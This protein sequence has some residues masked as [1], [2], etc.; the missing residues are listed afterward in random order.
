[1]PATGNA[2]G[3]TRWRASQE[4]LRTQ[5]WPLP[6][7]AI[8]VA[9][10]LGIGLPELD[11]R[12]VGELPGGWA[13]YLF[14][15][16]P[17]A[18]R[19]VL[20]A[21][22]G[23]LI[24]VT[25]LTFSLTIVTLQLASS[26]YSPRLLRTFAGDRVVHGTLAVL[27]GTFTYTLT[28]MRTVRTERSERPAFVPQLSVTVAYV[29]ALASV[30]AVVLF[31][32]HLAR[33]IRV[34]SILRDVHDSSA[35]TMRAVLPDAPPTGRTEPPVPPAG[36][37]IAVCAA[38]SGFFT[39]VDTARLLKAAVRADAVVHVDRQ[40]GDSLIAGT[41][42]A[43]AWPGNG[44]D[45]ADGTR[46]ALTDEVAKSLHTGFERTPAQDVGFG[47][48]QL[49]DVAVK[50]LSPGINDPTTAV[51]A[52][53]HSSS[54]LCAVVHRYLGP[55]L[56]TDDSGRVRVV[57]ARPDLA[58]LL[59]L[60]VSQVRRYGAAEP[61]V[62]AR[63]LMLLREVAWVTRDPDHHAAIAG[64]LVRVGSTVAAQ[65]FD[66]AERAALARLALLVERALAGE[67]SQAGSRLLAS[68]D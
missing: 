25:S 31:L 12:I 3:G 33:Q 15:G 23:S 46:A 44:R 22:A 55:Q 58:T 24:T 21:V 1:M 26:Q 27:L 38:K 11:Q 43:R 35:E 62:L 47:F 51:H 16:G 42:V 50:A 61:A 7:V 10:A 68:T 29:L 57:L 14:S 4:A 9:V 36:P 13:T 64:Q 19:A 67:W 53:S 39:F 52:L 56:L 49:V 20:G 2:A 32:A 40:L 66:D 45:F 65:R 17:D 8:L 63:L 34:E 41:P 30:I 37:A 60:V 18:A 48:R 5:V 6:A 54:L 59:D 28:V